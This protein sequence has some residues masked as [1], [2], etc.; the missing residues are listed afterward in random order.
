ML[1]QIFII[2]F[3]FNLI[4]AQQLVDG[5]GP[6]N[7]SSPINRKITCHPPSTVYP[8]LKM[9]ACAT[10]ALTLPQ[11]TEPLIFSNLRPQIW[12][13]QVDGCSLRVRFT[14]G[15][16]EEASWVFLHLAANTLI[17]V[18]SAG[19]GPR[20]MQSSIRTSQNG[21]IEVRFD[22]GDKLLKSEND[23]MQTL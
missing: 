10:A 22:T 17:N 20:M 18:C 11:S 5:I 12:G 23:T 15:P 8:T 4:F 14:G 13:A 9:M 2:S 6:A 1:V 16:D 7:L 21:R 3:L 19:L